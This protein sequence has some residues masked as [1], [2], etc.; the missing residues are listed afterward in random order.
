MITVIDLETSFIK[1]ESGRIDPLPFNPK[2]ILVSC[3]INSKYGDEYYF[4]NH[5]EKT[6]K[7]AAPRIQE[8]LDETTLLVGHNIKFDLTWL[9]ESGFKYSGRIYDTMIG[10]Y[11]LLRGIKNSLALDSICKKRKIGKKDDKIK[12]FLDRG[13]SFENI[14]HHIV[15]EYGRQD[16]MITKTLFNAQ[17]NDFKMDKNKHL[18]KT[19]KMMNEFTVVLT[20]MERNGIHVDINALADVEKQYRAEYAYLRAEIE[21]TIYNKMGDTKINPNSTEQ[22]SWLIYSRKVKDK[23]RWR[24]IFNIGVDKI[25]KKQKRR[26]QMSVSQIVRHI[27]EN[28]DVIYKTS[29]S[30]CVDCLGKGVIKKLKKDGSPYKNYSK[31]A[32]CDG[33]GLTYS[34]LGKVA[35]FNQKPKSIY[36]LADGGFKTDRITLQ[37]M[38][39]KASGE[40][41][42]FIDNIMRY[43]AIDTYLS[44]FVNGIKEYTNEDGLLHPKFMQCVTATGRLSSRDPNFQNQPRAKTF[45]IRSVIKSRFEGG[46]IL[47]IDFAQLEFRTAIFLSQDAQGIEDIKNNVDV[48]QY[49]ADIIGCSRQD[50]KA[51]TF[52][53]L[54][55]GVTG[56]ENEKKYYSAFLKKYK[57]IAE[58]HDKLQTEAITYKRV[59]LPTGRE[60]AFPYA[61]RMPWGGS[62]YGTQIK[63]YPVQGFA[64]ADI[65]PLACIKIYKLMKEQKVKSLLINT[66]HDSIVADVYPGEEDVMSDIFKQGTSSVVPTMKEYYGINFNVPLDSELKIGYNW[67]DMEEVA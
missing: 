10:E 27:N 53:P 57:Q 15:E 13:V 44:T 65:V 29:S 2:N 56:T 24:S 48:H 18:L 23:E 28:T 14:P 20:D 59:K 60:Y 55:G 58:W 45:P 34:N 26:P 8:V 39:A 6:S 64:T 49:T 36:D 7:G 21:K 61:E 51:H 3:G 63:N 50:A 12:E 46:R 4:L 31:C 52:K 22:L 47:E 33:E 40:L 9:L 38:G 54:Y 67:L 25:T 35:G 43:N 32:T 19:V 66:V 11:I 17:M 5:S 62:S 30:Q 37:K 16:V 42:D 1:E 41:K